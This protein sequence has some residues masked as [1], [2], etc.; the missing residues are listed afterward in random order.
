M[1]ISAAIRSVQRSTSAWLNAAAMP[2]SRDQRSI[3]SSGMRHMIAELITE[4]P[5]TAQ[6]C[7]SGIRALPKAAVEPR[8]RQAPF[9]VR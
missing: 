6:P 4:V 8:S 3:T 2:E 7:R 1:G 9:M 5:P